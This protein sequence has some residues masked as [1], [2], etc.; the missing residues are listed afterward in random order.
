MRCLIAVLA[1]GVLTTGAYG[2][3]SSA[4]QEL[5]RLKQTV[6][7]KPAPGVNAVEFYAAREKALHDAADAFVKQFPNDPHRP[8]ALLWRMQTTDLPESAEQRLELIKQDEAGAK[9]LENDNSLA[10]AGIT[11]SQRNIAYDQFPKCGSWIG[12]ARS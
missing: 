12:K 7:E 11:N 1:A 2:Q 6:E 4:W 3:E 5:Q 10:R 9:A 8:Q